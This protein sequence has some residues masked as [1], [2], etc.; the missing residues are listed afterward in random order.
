MNKSYKTV[1][2]EA[3]GAYVAVSEVARGHGKAIRSRVAL[4]IVAVLA[5][6]IE[7]AVTDAVAGALDGG[8]VTPDTN[9]VAYGPSAMTTYSG[10]VAVGP[11]AKAVG[12][13]YEGGYSVAIGN[14]ALARGDGDGGG[15]GFGTGG[16]GWT[17]A[18]GGGSQALH[19]MSTAVGGAASASALQSTAVGSSSTASV[20]GGVA[21]GVYS[22]A[23]RAAGAGGSLRGAVSVGSGGAGIA[24]G[25]RQII[26]VAR[27]TQDT[28]AVNVSQLK[29]VTTALGAGATVSSDGVITAPAYLMQGT[30]VTNVGSA[31][32]T[33]DTA[34]TKNRGDVTTLNNNVTDLFN[35]I[36]NGTIG[37]VQQDPV[38]RAITV[39]N[40]T[41]GSTVDF[42]G[43]AGA[44][45][46]RGVAAGTTDG[47]AVNLS[48]LKPVVVS[49]GGGATVNAD[50]SIT[51]PVYRIQGGTQTTVGDA[52]GTL[53]TGLTTLQ[54]QVNDS[55]GVGLVKQDRT[56]HDILVAAA[57]DGGRVNVA[58]TAGTRVVTGVAAGAVNATSVDAVN[59]SQLYANAAST[60][61]AF[62]GGATVNADGTISAPAYTVGGTTVNNVGAAISNIDDRLIKYTSDIG[63][64]QT[65]VNSISGVVAN[66]VQYDSAA[67]DKVTLGGAPGTS[68]TPVAPK[69]KLTNLQ[70]ADLSATSAD[71]VTGAQLW[72]TNQSVSDL[73]VTVKNQKVNG[74][75]QIS[76]NSTGGP[77]QAS[78]S[79]S[80]AIGGDARTSAPN[81][82]A[83]GEGAVAN[84][85]NTVSVGSQDSERR[86]VNLANGQSGTDAVNMR[87]F[88]SGMTDMARN[89][90]SGVAAASA[91]SM[92]PEVDPNRNFIV[93]LGTANYKGY[94]ASAIGAS[95]R[96]GQ[97]LKMKIAAGFSSGGA[98]VAGGVGYQW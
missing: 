88:Q 75:A 79:S 57:N 52:L 81:S 65:T 1:W 27:G 69:V 26:S 63:A 15:G 8:T 96:F 7:L 38:S 41:A 17:T 91:L 35:N 78:G 21:L 40:A 31:L 62:G 23:D 70:D 86:I 46:L 56:S 61:A 90:Y 82:V 10:N 83:L 72:T 34:V 51:G 68:A 59:G 6:G 76:I 42:T 45:E 93:G 80:V 53:D 89:A 73:S 18:L 67:H 29:G 19:D 12:G 47:S 16:W 37:I 85:P 2:N 74:S 11:E 13:A 32:D 9:S 49:L 20:T 87:Q 33:L 55:F 94:Q 50:G 98:A 71:A 5:T 14:K 64:V 4:A 84:Q 60:A 48:Q 92:I 66:S 95:M 25:T 3:S 36:N 54:G 39:A 22:V 77:A 30:T 24:T 97:N 28:D 43:T 44:R 58:G